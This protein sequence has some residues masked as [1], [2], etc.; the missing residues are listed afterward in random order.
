[1]AKETIWIE[2]TTFKHMLNYIEIEVEEIEKTAKVL[3]QLVEK[4]NKAIIYE[5]KI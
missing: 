3:R 1:M 4:F 5:E 2:K